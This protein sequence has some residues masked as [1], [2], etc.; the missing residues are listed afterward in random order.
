MTQLAPRGFLAAGIPAGPLPRVRGASDRIR[1]RIVSAGGRGKH[2]IR[3]TNQAGGVE[4][5]AVC[6][7]WDVRR[8]EGA[9]L[10]GKPK[11]HV[12]SEATVTDLIPRDA[13]DIV[14]LSFGGRLHT[15][16][17]GYRSIPAEQ[18]RAV[19]GSPRTAPPK[20][21]T[22]PMGSS[23]GARAGSRT[24]TWWT[25]TTR[26][27]PATSAT[28]PTK[29]SAAWSGIPAGICEAGHVRPPGSLRPRSPRATCRIHRLSP[30]RCVA[31]PTPEVLST[32]VT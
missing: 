19:G 14:F 23:A 21:A 28:S 9:A 26:P 12:I 17:H 16:R 1:L 27:W 22:R 2:R 20:W 30:R 24:P 11:V 6:D 4:W 25:A 10:I 15:F 7:A 18:H 13:A 31:S 3:M 29:K 8:D 5:V 32:A